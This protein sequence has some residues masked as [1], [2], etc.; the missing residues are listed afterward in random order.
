MKCHKKIG[1]MLVYV[2]VLFMCLE[3]GLNSL[4]RWSYSKKYVWN[5]G[6]KSMLHC[7]REVKCQLGEFN[8]RKTFL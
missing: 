2:D 3:C 8:I 4:G 7:F 1:L 6:T 5:L